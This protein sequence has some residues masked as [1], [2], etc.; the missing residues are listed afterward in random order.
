[1]DN[2]LIKSDLTA[3]CINAWKNTLHNLVRRGQLHFIISKLKRR[4]RYTLILHRLKLNLVLAG[5]LLGL[6]VGLT[7]I[8]INYLAKESGYLSTEHQ[9]LHSITIPSYLNID[10]IDALE[11][12][13]RKEL[14]LPYAKSHMRIRPANRFSSNKIVLTRLTESWE[15]K[16]LTHNSSFSVRYWK[17]D[18][19]VL[20][21]KREANF[22]T[23]LKNIHNDLTSKIS[24]WVLLA[25]AILGGVSSYLVINTL[26]W[27]RLSYLRLLSVGFIC[28]TLTISLSLV[29]NSFSL[30]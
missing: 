30:Y 3:N 2:P 6:L 11:K 23:L 21:L 15:I 28:I 24:A 13:L 27:S 19:D 18:T 29:L 26:I 1:M 8:V 5:C 4:K 12:W 25:D 16:F 22:W 7:C 9:E 20:I 14:K 17:G 10:S